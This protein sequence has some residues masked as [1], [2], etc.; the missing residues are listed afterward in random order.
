MYACALITISHRQDTNLANNAQNEM[1]VRYH[2]GP[3]TGNDRYLRA[4][5]RL[6]NS[7]LVGSFGV[8]QKFTDSTTGFDLTMTA[9][10]TVNGVDVADILVNFCSPHNHNANN[11]CE[12]DMESSPCEGVAWKN[13]DPITRWCRN[14]QCIGSADRCVCCT[15]DHPFA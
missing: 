10:R 12:F 4:S 3:T 2:R 14:R 8:G 5:V 15:H 7:A 9:R 13:N 1:Y 6:S 11:P